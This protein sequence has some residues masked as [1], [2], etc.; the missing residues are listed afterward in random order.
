MDDKVR[1][2][3]LSLTKEKERER[4]KKILGGN[5][6]K[7]DESQANRPSGGNPYPSPQRRPGESR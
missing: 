2:C 6:N 7:E 3:D 4:E 1:Q 5:D